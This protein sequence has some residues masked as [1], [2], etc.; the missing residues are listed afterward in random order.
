MSPRSSTFRNTATPSRVWP[1]PVRVLASIAIAAHFLMLILNYGSNNSLRRS[2]FA[3]Q[4]LVTLQPYLITL[5]WY[6]EFAP[7]SLATGETFDQAMTIEY[8]TNR[9]D[10]KWTSWID[11][12]RSD[13]R[14]R[15]LA[16]LAGALAEHDDADGIGLIAHSL[17][18]RASQEGITI[19]R[20]RFAMDIP[21]LSDSP[22]TVYEASVIRLDESDVAL[23]PQIEATR[24]VPAVP[25]EERTG[26]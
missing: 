14:W 15:R 6:T 8:K 18:H 2:E 7:V 5:G 13:A 4:A 26:S 23:I 19:D 11:S 10:R 20:I 25:A 17:V 24:S 9:R 12:K 3:D 22:S 1:A 16:A 21:S